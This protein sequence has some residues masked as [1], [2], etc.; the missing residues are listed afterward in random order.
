M[1]L[2]PEIVEVV[3]RALNYED[4]EFSWELTTAGTREW[5]SNLAQVALTAA[6]PLIEAAALE[7]AAKVC[8]EWTGQILSPT[9]GDHYAFLIRALK[10][11][12]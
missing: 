8:E 7:R 3:A 5:Y 10:E 12:P 1:K 11:Q 2:D 6:Y 4:G 9:I